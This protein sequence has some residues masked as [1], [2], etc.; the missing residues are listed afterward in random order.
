MTR[1]QKIA[2]V[3]ALIVIGSFFLAGGP[4]IV[5]KAVK[6]L[7]RSLDDLLPQVRAKVEQL[8]AN[9]RAKGIETTV[10]STLRSDEQQDALGGA[11]A[12]QDSWHE[13]GRGLDLY[14]HGP[15]GKADRDGKYVDRFYLMHQEAAKLGFR[16]IAFNDL[17]PGAK[18]VKR[19]ITTRSGKKT[20]DG[21]HLE[22]REGMTFA[23]AEAQYKKLKAGVA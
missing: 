14:P 18:P 7:S 4:K 2:L 19:I 3:I 20:W 6:G 17:T 23:Q 9:L 16:G 15:D 10:G 12:T 5:A 8:R 1:N 13:L 22:Y 11:S 21:G